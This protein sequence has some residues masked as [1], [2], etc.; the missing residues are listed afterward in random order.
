MLFLAWYDDSSRET[1]EKI[2]DAIAA[3]EARFG[4]S[5]NLILVNKTHQDVMV[6]GMTVRVSAEVRPNIFWV[7]YEA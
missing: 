1:G 4:G 6:P 7:G 2:Q 5:A 3:Y